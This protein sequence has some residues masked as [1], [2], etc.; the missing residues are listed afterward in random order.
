MDYKKSA[1]LVSIAFLIFTSILASIYVISGD[2]CWHLS[3]ARFIARNDKMPL[4]EPLGRTD[5]FWPPPLYHIFTAFVYSVSGSI[6][7]KFADTS[8]KFVSVLFSFLTLI[9]FYLCVKKITSK[10]V[11]LFSA[12]GL[13]SL[14]L[15]IDY[16][17]LAYVE[18]MLTFFVV[19]SVYFALENR[20]LL[21]GIT[22]GLASLTKY[23]GILILP[24]LAYLFYKNKIKGSK[25]S[26]IWLKGIFL[27]IV[28]PLLIMAPWLV[29]NWENLHNPIWPFLNP[30]FNGYTEFNGSEAPA[31]E[32]INFSNL[33]DKR[34]YIFTYLG[35]FGVPDGD[36]RNLTF[37]DVP[38]LKLLLTF[39]SIITLGY[40]SFFIM[41]I[42][43]ILKKEKRHILAVVLIWL[44]P[45][46]PLFALY[47]AN[48][49]FSVSRIILPTV[50][51]LAVVWGMGAES[52][53]AR[54]S[55]PTLKKLA[56]ILLA[57][58]IL[59]L[60]G[61]EFT[62]FAL[63]R[64][65]WLAYEDDFE[66]A[67][68]NTPQDSIFLLGGQCPQYHIDRTSSQPILENL[69]I[70]DYIWINQHF[71]LERRS[72]MDESLV[73][74]IREEY[75]LAY[76]NGKTGTDIYRAKVTLSS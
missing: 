15:F 14:P 31:H 3:A 17:V 40:T 46:I 70:V 57:G 13:A 18:S 36:Y 48:V 56:A 33:L 4:F 65:A 26:S 39:W 63:A 50:P 55:R 73:K 20:F 60:A 42:K 24:L 75:E 62:K 52:L 2:G 1:I 12:I 35:F 67:K 59:A 74:Q 9:F 38:Y 72:I 28:L 29:R 16:A 54:I 11:A 21:A 8:T 76:R 47:I 32:A 69:P 58:I 37:F 19:L 27:V 43:N 71:N 25:N 49:S 10:R 23:N 5:P 66:W 30:V 22:A 6:S 45:S 64:N 34:A 61:S 51:A 7:E 53:F 44:L 41:G 68:A